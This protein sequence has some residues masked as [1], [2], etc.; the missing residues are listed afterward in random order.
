MGMVKVSQKR[1]FK[2]REN[3]SKTV[4]MLQ[5]FVHVYNLDKSSKIFL[6]NNHIE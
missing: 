5:N 6:S 3:G 2:P 1:K 4:K